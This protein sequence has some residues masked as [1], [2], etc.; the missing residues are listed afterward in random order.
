MTDKE[1]P[2]LK[3][4]MFGA[5]GI[6]YGDLGTSPLYTMQT[7]LQ[8]SGGDVSTPTV[9]GVMSLIVWALLLIVS[10]KYGVFVMKA[11]NHGEGG[12]L[13]LTAL[14]TGVRPGRPASGP[15]AVVLIG[16]GLF[17]AALLYGDGILTP[18]ISVL[19][20]VE[21][22]QVATPA[23]GHLVM[24]IA[25]LIL[26]GLFCL[27][28]FGTARIGTLF[29][30]IMLLWF[31][32]IGGLGA[33]ALLRHPEVIKAI[34]P[35][36]GLHT[37]GTHGWGSLAVLG[38]V[39]LAVTGSEALY[40]DM[41][42]VGRGPIRQ[43]WYAIV[44]PA[45]LLCYAGQSASLI[46]LKTLPENPFYGIL[47]PAIASWAIWPMVVLATLATIIA[48]QAIIT[49]VFSMTRQAIQLGWFPG[50]NIRQTSDEAYGQI[51]VPAVNWTMMIC[52]VAIAVAFGRA[53]NLSGAYGVA[54]ATTML[55]T[56][57]LL[58]GYLRR[59]AAWSLAAALPLTGCFLFVDLSFFI[60]NLLKF[61]DGGYVPL[62][63]GV[64]VFLAM[65]TWRQGI[66][67]L[68]ARSNG[69]L[70]TADAF[71]RQLTESQVPRV[72]GTIVFL[73]RL[74]E[75]IPQTLVA[76]VEQFGALQRSVVI[77]TVAFEERPRIAP[78][79]RITLQRFEGG[80]WYVIAHYGFVEIPNL[81]GALRLAHDEG[82]PIV[83][84][85]ALFIGA[86]DEVVRDRRQ[87]VPRLASWRRML[88]GF[89]YRNAVHSAD[90]F[91]LPADRF[92]QV[93]RQ[94]GL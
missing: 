86:R 88:F 52:T 74:R 1:T 64:L 15:T 83:P 94:I 12:I 7:V 34:D 92:V 19:S 42:H 23:L 68:K 20:A 10:V 31:V 5:L 48:S 44:L 79:E 46:G 61:L 49:G 84:G 67:G 35:R 45:L 25:A 32:T 39:F 54:I 29:G 4:A 65:S 36:Y 93:G 62:F 71:V 8:S 3:A 43:A 24:P 40:A 56:T 51:Y 66:A 16:I 26:V 90:R 57:T 18:A 89:M 33:L 14:V 11:D 30:P 2:G 81:T 38:S 75:P 87:G 28:P 85:D 73:S 47:P 82:C 91:T 21:G 50:L 22:I 13:A 41:G 55:L 78:N 9:L 58:F 72:P 27:Q 80:V 59:S 6:V 63:I 77:L 70:P 37:L 69:H 17:G 76:H 53:A 60:A